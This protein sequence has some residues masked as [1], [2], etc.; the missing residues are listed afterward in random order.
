MVKTSTYTSKSTLKYGGHCCVFAFW[1]V[2]NSRFLLELLEGSILISTIICTIEDTGDQAFICC[3]YE[4][5]EHLMFWATGKYLKNIEDRRD[6]VQDSIVAL[7]NNLETVK[8]LK[9]S[10]LLTYIV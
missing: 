2:I 5:Y 8:T 6:A 4:K 3:L 10:Y 1:I 7:I 9:D